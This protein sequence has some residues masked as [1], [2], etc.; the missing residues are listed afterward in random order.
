MTLPKIIR[1]MD[2][3]DTMIRERKPFQTRVRVAPY[4]TFV[5]MSGINPSENRFV[6]LGRA[7]DRNGEIVEG[8]T[9]LDLRALSVGHLPRE[10]H[11]SLAA[12]DFVVYSYDTPIA[13]HHD[14]PHDLTQP[15][16]VAS[17]LNDGGD[18]V[19]IIPEVKYTVTTTKHQGDVRAALGGFGY[20]LYARRP[21][22]TVD[23]STRA[24]A[25]PSVP[26]TIPARPPRSNTSRSSGPSTDGRHDLRLRRRARRSRDPARC[27]RSRAAH[28]R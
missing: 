12:A 13:W 16:L 15:E 28:V 4:G 9:A 1:T 20:G 18:G 24:P 10:Y 17:W 21:D 27:T 22:G 5:S 6:S 19:W 23:Y 25:L 26:L 2:D 8:E 7:R 14:R 11:D 3:A